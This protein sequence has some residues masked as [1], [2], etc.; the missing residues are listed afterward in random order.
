MTVAMNQFVDDKELA[1]WLGELRLPYIR[2]QLS[3]L[4]AAAVEEELNLR[5]FLI[6]LCRKEPDTKRHQRLAQH[7]QQARFPMQ[8]TL[9]DF[10][11]KA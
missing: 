11:F 4:L 9:N 1:G 3:N 7:V 5:D 6:M 10:E 2:A 8:R